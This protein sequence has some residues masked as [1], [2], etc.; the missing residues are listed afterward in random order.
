MLRF[1]DLKRVQQNMGELSV[2]DYVATAFLGQLDAWRADFADR[3]NDFDRR[4]LTALVHKM[5]GSCQAIAALGVAH[6]FAKAEQSLPSMLANDWPDRG[7]KLVSRLAEL[8]AE[9]RRI[10]GRVDGR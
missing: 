2:F 1:F 6:E 9:V 8:E 4:S 10:M 5:K 3:S 7:A